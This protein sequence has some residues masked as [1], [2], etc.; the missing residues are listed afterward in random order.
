MKSSLIRLALGTAVACL[1]MTSTL[2][3]DVRPVAGRVPAPAF[4]LKD[5]KGLAVKLADFKGKVVLLN[6]WATWCTPCAE[7]IPWFIEFQKT[8][9]D[10]GFEVLGVSVDEKGWKVVNQYL[11]EAGKAINYTIVLDDLH[12]SEKYAVETMPKTLMIDRDGKVAQV[13]NGLVDKAETE[14]EIQTL[15]AQAASG[16]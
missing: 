12:I 14:K 6:F 4:K 5:P 9:K 3:A 8:Y 1:V 13:H 11:A 7:E 16:K 10:K 15:L 2:S